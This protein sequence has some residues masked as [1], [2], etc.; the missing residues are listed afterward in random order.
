MR[1]K[2]LTLYSIFTIFVIACYQSPA[3]ATDN[4]AKAGLAQAQA[5]AKKWK[6]DAT[7]VQLLTFT[8]NADG[9][10]D[11][12]TYVFHSSKAKRGYNVNVS[13]GKV[14]QA[15][16]VSASF[17]NS[18]SSDFIDSVEVIAEAKKNGLKV[19]GKAMMMLHVMLQGTKN[20]GAYWNI[21]GD[22]TEENSMILDA[23]T[24]KF[25]RQQKFQ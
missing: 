4:T 22:M 9:T 6:A 17:T 2:Q 19:K 5:S 21:L 7:L 20:E 12:W 11:K 10:A 13:D 15:L 24:G 8:G 14:V 1:A 3:L 18:V 25:Y 23:K 16:D